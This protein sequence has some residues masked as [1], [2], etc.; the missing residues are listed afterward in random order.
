MSN[1][2]MKYNSTSLL[3]AQINHWGK[4][5]D[6]E[7]LIFFTKLSDDF[8]L[9]LEQNH[10]YNIVLMGD[11]FSAL[12]ALLEKK[13]I[14]KNIYVLSNA[15]KEVIEHFFDSSSLSIIVINRYELFP[16]KECLYES[17]KRII[18]SGRLSQS[19]NF[20]LAY[21]TVWHLIQNYYQDCKF[22]IL[23]QADNAK[24]IAQAE[25]WTKDLI[26]NTK[27]KDD[28]F[29]LYERDDVYLNGFNNF[30]F[31]KNQVEVMS[32]LDSTQWL[33][34]LD[35][36]HDIL[37]NLSAYYMDD[38]GVSVAQAQAIGMKCILSPIGGH[39]DATET[40]PIF[41]PT[42]YIKPTSWFNCPYS[43][44]FERDCGLQISRYIKNILE[45]KMC[46]SFSFS[47]SNLP[48]EIKTP[49]ELYQFDFKELSSDKGLVFSDTQQGRSFFKK[50]YHLWMPIRA[51]KKALILS[52]YEVFYWF[53]MQDI[54]PEAESL[55]FEKLAPTYDIDRI[56]I[57]EQTDPK[58]YIKELLSYDIII[59][60]KLTLRIA[61]LIR[62]IRKFKKDINFIVYTHEI[63][64]LLGAPY[65][66]LDLEE[67]FQENDLFIT[68]SQA[69]NS[70]H[71]MTF[72]N[73]KSLIIPYKVLNQQVKTSYKPKPDFIYAG[74]I[75]EQ[76][77][78]H[79]LIF[80]IF[81]LKKN[82]NFE[83][84][85]LEIYGK[86]DHFGNPNMGK[87]S[88][89]YLA[90]LLELI[91]S[92]DLTENIAIYNFISPDDL[93]EIY[94][95]KQK[96]FI[97]FSLHHD[98]NFGIAPFD[99]LSLGTFSILSNWGG[100]QYQNTLFSDG[101]ELIPVQ[102]STHGPF[103]CPTQAAQKIAA[104]LNLPRLKVQN[105]A[106]ALKEN[107]LS[108]I[109][110][111]GNLSLNALSQ[112]QIS[113]SLN[114]QYER[115]KPHSGAHYGKVFTGFD[116]PIFLEIC[117]QYGMKDQMLDFNQTSMILAPWVHI[118][119]DI[120]S[121]HDPYL[122]NLTIK[123]D[124]QEDRQFS[125]YSPNNKEVIVSEFEAKT[126]WQMG[127]LYAK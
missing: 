53:S 93:K 92:L 113:K 9:K 109:S 126:L 70:L 116:D 71:Q 56:A 25:D 30:R 47:K 119:P 64:S 26:A 28:Q 94:T 84:V 78:L 45:T 23:G 38:F 76:K 107:I 21:L 2:E 60:T 61:I 16:S 125:V 82:F 46:N 101:V 96:I 123:R 122:G 7:N 52:S 55:W 12:T 105:H 67:T 22:I 19:K 51:Q 41:V 74:R 17:P 91:E 31:N 86:E 65:K 36:K 88:S 20:E 97:S 103:I 34:Y 117:N 68:S 13:I 32:H 37:I 99:A 108:S 48:K 8:H 79:T 62:N 85:S 15:V 95:K 40:E 83:N 3:Q 4:K 1:N 124:Q 24:G 33:E 72:S 115:F 10:S 127:R 66:Y 75:S 49:Q 18:F 77:N 57:H 43:K 29:L 102:S 5:R 120:I 69:D 54:L 114:K 58:K 39:L 89:S 121:I 59:I 81:F 112:T 50:Y 111:D 90:Y 100:Y 44:R 106:K 118:R 63:P 6:I 27:L 104:I 11:F 110:F 80:A 14:I 87:T 35:P 42:Q 98:E 73:S